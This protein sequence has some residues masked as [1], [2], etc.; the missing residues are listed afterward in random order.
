MHVKSRVCLLILLQAENQ[1]VHQE[2]NDISK[3]LSEE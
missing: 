1:R 3:Q 2:I